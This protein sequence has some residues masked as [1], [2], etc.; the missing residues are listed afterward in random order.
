MVGNQER[1]NDEPAAQQG[2]GQWCTMVLVS[3]CPR[4]AGDV[5]HKTS[6]ERMVRARGTVL[7][8]PVC[9]SDT[10]QHHH[11][12]LAGTRRPSSSGLD[13]LSSSNRSAV[14]SERLRTSGGRRPTC[15]ALSPLVTSRRL[16]SASHTA[17]VIP[18]NSLYISEVPISPAEAQ[19][20][21]SR[22]VV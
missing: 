7:S 8:C 17:C 13:I 15:I 10:A 14:P 4:F 1:A 3:A 21:P 16:T 18:T 2:S 20:Q 5:V 19:C 9:T 12:T 6:T 22:L 11:H